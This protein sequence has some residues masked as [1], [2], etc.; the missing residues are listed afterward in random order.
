MESLD[1]IT[2][3]QLA[4]QLDKITIKQLATHLGISVSTVRNR[5]SKGKLP[6]PTERRGD[7]LFWSK[8]DLLGWGIDIQ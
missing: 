7:Q 2:I 8:Y 3:E 5:L 6:N 1:K 4:T